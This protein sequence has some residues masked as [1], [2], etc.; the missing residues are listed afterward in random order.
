MYEDHSIRSSPC[1]DR[2]YSLPVTHM[3]SGFVLILMRTLHTRFLTLT[4]DIAQLLGCVMWDHVLDV[5]D[6]PS[7]PKFPIYG[8]HSGL[9]TVVAWEMSALTYYYFM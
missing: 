3:T 5:S 4:H 9:C 2:H 8:E 6:S 1:L 7:I